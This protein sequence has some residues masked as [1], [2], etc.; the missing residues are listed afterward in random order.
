LRVV[1]VVRG[2]GQGGV[3]VSLARRLKYTPPDV[4]TGVLSTEPALNTLSGQVGEY[5]NDLVEFDAGRW[6]ARKLAEQIKLL[7]PDIVVSH[8]PRETIKILSS[9]LPRTVPVVVVAHHPE[10]SERLWARTPI[11]LALRQLDPRAA[12]HIAVSSAAASGSQCRRAR[13]IEILPLGAEID[14]LAPDSSFWPDGCRIKLLSLG[15]LRR[16]KSLDQLLLGVSS[17]A[18]SMRRNSAFLTI[19]GSGPEHAKISLLIEQLGLSDIAGIYPSVSNP[20][21]VLRAAD[22]LVI[23]STSEGGPVTAMEALLAGC[24]VVTTKTGLS[25]ELSLQ[26]NQVNLIQ[27]LSV[28]SIANALEKVVEKS[29]L[30]EKERTLNS[31]ASE[32]WSSERASHAFYNVL[33]EVLRW[34]QLR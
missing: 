15:R 10:S 34:P 20:S 28:E 14:D 7:K 9:S 26:H 13:R 6:G 19:V 23:T 12:L 24:R 1:E 17:V 30:T 27:D 4:W 16:F 29:P 32:I 5:A 2:L 25:N 21:Q 22:V 8:I 18:A 3:E 11:S 31:M 33:T